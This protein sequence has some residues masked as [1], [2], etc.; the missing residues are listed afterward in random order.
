[1]IL[2]KQTDFLGYGVRV[3]GKNVYISAALFPKKECGILIFDVDNK[4]E[5]AR[6]T[7]DDSFATG[8]VY[9]CV[10]NM[11]NPE[12][13]CYRFFEDDET[14]ADT[15]SKGIIRAEDTDFSLFTKE[16]KV[17]KPGHVFIPSED[18]VYYLAH[19]KG[20]TKAEK[21]I[22]KAAGT[23]KGLER[24]IDYMK[25]LGVTSIMLMP[26]YEVKTPKEVSYRELRRAPKINYWGFGAA[27]HFAV[28]RD[29]CLSENCDRE[30]YELVSE[31]HASEME[32]IF[33]MNFLNEKPDYI[34]SV[35]RYYIEKFGADGFRLLGTDIP[36]ELIVN[37]PLFSNTKFF[38][39]DADISKLN[40]IHPGKCRNIVDCSNRFLKESRA[41]LKGDEDKVSYISYAVRENHNS[42]G[43]VRNVTDFSGLTLWDMV[44]YNRKHNEDNGE[45]NTD[46]TDYNYSWNCGEEG[47][48]SKRLINRLRLK[49]VRN[50]MMLTCLCQSA[51]MLVA[52]DEI[53]NTQNGNNNPYCQDN[54]TGWVTYS[55]N[56]ASKEFREFVKALLGFRKRHVILHQPKEVMLFDYMSCKIPDV[57]FHSDE[58]FRYDQTPNSRSFGIFYCGDY[59]RQYTKETESSVYII[60][61]MNWEASEFVLPYKEGS[62]KLLYCTEQPKDESFD[63]SKALPYNKEKYVAPSRSVSVFLYDRC[64]K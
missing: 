2:A 51:P 17:K 11:D 4:S 15:F 59:A 34:I 19:V 37:E 42:F 35:L 45:D 10:L 49:Q 30:L 12:K 25:D 57:S 60:F 61:N 31:L 36:Y 3:N 62:W 64:E 18:S 47:H 20:L 55:G 46:G 50:A 6:I 48:S 29:F 33:L 16:E 44:C 22:G 9:S 13:Y 54:T 38:I 32:V 14:F 21:S 1:M 28:K 40:I 23:F 39:E 56:K 53:L 26:V 43:S 52:G 63:E 27:Y 24:K 7:F 8:S 58:A 5:I 41:F